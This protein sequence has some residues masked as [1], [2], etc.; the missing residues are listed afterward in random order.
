[1]K[2]V[3][4][5]TSLIMT[6][7]MVI[8]TLTCSMATTAD[9]AEVEPNNDPAN[10]TVFTFGASGVGSI[11]DI[12]D[13]DCFA[14]TAAQSGVAKIVMTITGSSENL[15]TVKDENLVTKTYYVAKAGAGTSS[16]FDVSKG[17]KYYIVIT[18]GSVVNQS[19]Y[20]INLSVSN[21]GAYE[22]EANNS[23]ATATPIT[24][25]KNDDTFATFGSISAG[26]TDYF[27]FS[28]ISGGYVNIEFA[29][30]DYSKTKL[31]LELLVVRATGDTGTKLAETYVNSVNMKATTADIGIQNATYYIK[32][33]GNTADTTGS[34]T[35]QVHRR[36]ST[37]VETEYNG[38]YSNANSFVLKGA[39]GSAINIEGKPVKVGTIGYLADKDFYK[40]T[41]SSDD[42][43]YAVVFRMDTSSDDYDRNDPDGSFLVT[44]YNSSNEVV[45]S[46]TATWTTPVEF[47]L[48]GRDGG[49]YYFTVEK[50]NTYT[51]GCYYFTVK[52]VEAVKS[53]DNSNKSLWEKI[54]DLDWQGFWDD[55]SFE[56]LIGNIDIL[57]TL[58]SLAKLSIGTILGW[59]IK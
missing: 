58:Y 10:A 12:Y 37:A 39:A 45:E 24:F 11:K 55:N 25:D 13:V 34:Y 5:I 41:L 57:G 53:D 42:K 9:V 44:L 36:T 6:F 31:N 48:A 21:Y 50:G 19:Q 27:S 23:L 26:D 16:E 47:N 49:N 18:A 56:E 14:V 43:N 1:M 33:T 7:V 17:E 2:K 20:S 51:E 3:K 28:G 15:V 59:L 32:V 40:F 30:T 4:V 52:T 22:V 35:V 29:N 38:D 46:K 54:K 8:G